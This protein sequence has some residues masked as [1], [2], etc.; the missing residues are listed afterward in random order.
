MTANEVEI[1]NFAGKD[2]IPIFRSTSMSKIAYNISNPET[3]KAP[4]SP[5]YID[6]FSNSP[7]IAI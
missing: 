1:P 6:Q 4:A 3:H 2:L 5:R 7:I